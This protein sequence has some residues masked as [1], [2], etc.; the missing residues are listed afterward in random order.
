[1]YLFFS[2][3]GSKNDHIGVLH[4][5]SIAVYSLITVT[6]SAEHG[7]QSQLY[8]AYEHQL[9][10]CAYNM[11]VGGFGGVVG[12]DFLCIQSLDGA[13]MFFEQETLALTRTLPNFLLPSP[14][15]YVPHTDSFVILNSEWFLESYR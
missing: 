6:G 8:L 1:I 14:I 11:I 12:R 9:K 10:R 15:A 4:P 13:L 7:D 3:R 2:S 5:R